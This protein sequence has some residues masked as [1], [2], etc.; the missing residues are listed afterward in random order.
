M[1]LLSNPYRSP[2]LAPALRCDK[3][4]EHA[5]RFDALREHHIHS[6]IEVL[7]AIRPL[8]WVTPWAAQILSEAL[9]DNTRD[10]AKIVVVHVVCFEFGVSLEEGLELQVRSCESFEREGEVPKVYIASDRSNWA[11]CAH[12]HRCP[13][14]LKDLTWAVA[15]R[16]ATTVAAL[17]P[18]L[19]VAA[20]DIRVPIS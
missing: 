2:R 9:L 17:A 14:A 5:A 7:H 19:R 8:L 10:G 15:F 3:I 16:G 12:A 13:N 11:L 4:P 20:S 1:L 6:S 18:I